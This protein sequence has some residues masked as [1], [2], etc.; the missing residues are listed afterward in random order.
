MF[1]LGIQGS[2]RL[3]GNTNYLLSSFMKEAEN[4]GAETK[5]IE[6]ANIDLKP[7]KGCM[8][9][10]TH[11][12]CSINDNM[13]TEFCP[14]LRRADIVVLATPIYFYTCP[15]LVKG[16]ID[17]SQV[18]WA[19]RYKLGMPIDPG[20]K[21]RKG[22]LLTVGATKGKN[23]FEGMILTSKYFFDAVNAKYSGNLVYRLMEEPDDMSKHPT[24]TDDI[25]N[26][27]KELVEPL[28]SRKKILFVSHGDSC[29]GQMASAFTQ[30]YASD[31]FE[32]ESCGINPLKEVDPVMMEVM[33]EKNID[34]K[35]LSPK[36]IDNTFYKTKPDIAVYIDNNEKI[37][38]KTSCINIHWNNFACSGKNL[39]KMRKVRDDI[40]NKVKDLI[41]ELI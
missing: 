11:G 17:R 21:S 36:K 20:S 40:E 39:D 23:L 13:E 26:S 29:S 24:V 6:A 30:I 18:M 7:C 38:D 1:I 9:C 32:V 19:R 34:M 37:Y 16:Y 12:R 41:D 5:I 15:A 4:Y 25:K 10:E 22:F 14:Q 35:Y 2:P 31:N 3:N 33:K 27:V 8:F 28:I